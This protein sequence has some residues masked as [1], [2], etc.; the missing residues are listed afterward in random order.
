MKC[1]RPG[2][3]ALPDRRMTRSYWLTRFL[4][5]RLLGRRLPR[6]VP[7]ARAT[8]CCRSSATTGCCRRTLYLERLAQHF[9]SRGAAALQV[10]SLF[11][12]GVSDGALLA[13]AWLGVALAALVVARL[14]ERARCSCV[15]WALYMSFVHVG[16]DWYGYG[17]E[18]QLLET[19]FLAIFLCPLLDARPFPRR[20]P[21]TAV[22]LAVSLADL[23]H[24]AR[25][26][27]HQAARRS[28]LARPHLPLLP[29]RDA[30]DARTR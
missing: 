1:A 12:L 25:R 3:T 18:I 4:I 2:A 14:R 8:R 13:A 23:P 10:P 6:R 16:Q 19:G 11:W 22:D 20:P 21:P 28:V 30:A 7:R 29:L 24:H 26:G 27:A 5:L 9:G 15:L 17:W